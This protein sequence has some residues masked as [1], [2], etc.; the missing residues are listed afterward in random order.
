MCGSELSGKPE[1][2]QEGKYLNLSNMPL[3]LFLGNAR[4]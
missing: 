4:L 1:R 2:M 3:L